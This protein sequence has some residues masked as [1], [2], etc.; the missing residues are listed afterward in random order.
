MAGIGNTIGV[1]VKSS[2][3]TKLRKYTS[4]AHICVYLNISK[5]LPSSISLEYHDEDWSQT[6][7]YEHISFRYRKCHEH[8]HLF[9]DCPLNVVSKGEKPEMSKAKDG[10]IPAVGRCRQVARKTSATATRE[11]PSSNPFDDLHQIPENM[12]APQVPPTV[13][14]LHGYTK[15]KTMETPVLEQ[16]PPISTSS[17]KDDEPLDLEEGDIK[18]DLDE[19]DLTG[20]DLEHLEQAYRHQQLYTI[21]PD[22]LRK[23][24][25]VFLDPSAGSTA[26]SN[27][28]LGI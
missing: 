6:I 20:I 21:P 11:P 4:Y 3:A 9:R 8:R 5:P 24:H 18:M 7:D 19:Q 26:R 12:D 23:V 28:G 16:I 17:T 2:E 22:Q 27:T 14:A 25:K 1:Y 13:D 10:F 15:G